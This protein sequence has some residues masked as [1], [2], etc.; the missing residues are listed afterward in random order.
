MFAATVLCTADSGASAQEILRSEQPAGHQANPAG[1]ESAFSRSTGSLDG[2]APETDGTSVTTLQPAGSLSDLIAGQTDTQ[3]VS[4]DLRCLAGAIYFEARHE[5]LPGQLAVGRV[6]V[7]RTKSGRFPKSYCGVV[8]QPSQFSFIHA[9]VMPDINEDSPSW[10]NAV[11]LARIA[12][13]G[14]WQSPVEGALFFHAARIS[15]SWH[16]Q[17][18]AQVD[19]HV[20]YR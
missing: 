17:R 18:I 1:S 15:P 13:A 20:F 7:A 9:H 10:H 19:H 8:Y 12:D 11:A 5:S 14:T 6:V 16:R 3:N 4:P 2:A